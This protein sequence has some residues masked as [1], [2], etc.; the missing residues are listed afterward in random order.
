MPDVFGVLHD[1]ILTDFLRTRRRKFNTDQRLLFGKD[2]NGFMFPLQLQLQSLTVTNNDEFIFIAMV[3]PEKSKKIP[4]YCIID[5]E[6]YIKDCTASFKYLFYKKTKKETNKN[7][8]EI[9]VNY[10]DEE[11]QEESLVV[12]TL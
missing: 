11:F 3:K 1:K 5:H 12:R 9:V 2:G 4:I 8:Q 6:G 10:F 7:I